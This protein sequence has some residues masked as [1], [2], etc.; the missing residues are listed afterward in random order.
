MMTPEVSRF[1]AQ[2][3][4]RASPRLADD[5]ST[6]EMFD[7]MCAWLKT[8][9]AIREAAETNTTARVADLPTWLLELAAEVGITR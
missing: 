1:S 7:R 9:A 4:W 2:V 3:L 5:L 6:D 8:A